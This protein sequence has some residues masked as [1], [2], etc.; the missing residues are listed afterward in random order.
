MWFVCPLLFPTPP[1]TGPAQLI[2]IKFI[3]LMI[4]KLNANTHKFTGKKNSVKAWTKNKVVTM[5]LQNIL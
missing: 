3:T 2:V 5:C 4:A 1:A